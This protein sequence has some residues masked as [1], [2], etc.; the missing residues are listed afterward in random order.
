MMGSANRKNK[1]S[2]CLL[3]VDRNS[4][5][6]NQSKATA[7]HVAGD[8]MLLTWHGFL[9]SRSLDVRRLPAKLLHRKK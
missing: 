9:R 5:K 3:G 1:N 8:T 7:I 6:A 4:L 2:N